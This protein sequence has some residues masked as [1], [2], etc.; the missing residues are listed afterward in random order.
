MTD[1]MR[2][3][4]ARLRALPLFRRLPD[5]KLE[6]LARILGVQAAPAGGLIFEEGAPGDAIFLLAA[7]RV[8]IEK[9]VEAGGFAELAVLSPGD[10]FGE[11]ALIERLPHSARAV[12]DTNATL[13]VLAGPAAE[14]WL[15]S[16]AKMALEFVVELLRVLSQ[17]LRRSSRSVTLLYDIGVLA[18]RRYEDEAGFVTAVLDRMLSHLEGEW[19]AAVYIYNEFNDEVAQV[20][21]VGPQAVAFAGTL[22]LEVGSCSGLDSAAFCVALAGKGDAPAGFLLARNERVMTAAEKSEAEVAL[23]AVGHL[24]ASALRNIQLQAD[25]RMRDRLE[26]Q[27]HDSPL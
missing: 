22:P 21:A 26:D 14:Q 19:S 15:A 12:A 6:E 3:R 8:R 1:D 2:D 18:S 27:A 10:V 23:T 20:A 24:V 11:M 17:R 5:P 7:G 9:R 16:D 13:F 25:Q 4:V